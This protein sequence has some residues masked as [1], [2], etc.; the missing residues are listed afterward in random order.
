MSFSSLV[1]GVAALLLFTVA[2]AQQTVPSAETILKEAT[3]KAAKEKKK[4]L[5]IFHASWCGWCHK[6]DSAINDP[7]CKQF[8]EDHYVI[9]HITVYENT[10]ANKGL[11]NPGGLEILAKYNGEKEGLPYWVILDKDATLL[12]DSKIRPKE[13]AGPGT[14]IG[15]PAEDNEIE[16]FSSV[17]KKTSTLKDDELAIIAERFKKIKGS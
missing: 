12:A 1:L 7:S 13:G 14:N 5:L 4:V 17:L 10:P 16:Y 15:C 8:F 6:M 2:S 11:E 3:E 9:S